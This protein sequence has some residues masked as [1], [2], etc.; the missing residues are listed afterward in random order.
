MAEKKKYNSILVSG[1]KDETLT[2]SKYIKDEETGE[3][4]KES[5]D[6]KVNVTD[7]LETHQIKDGAITNEK[8]AAD[9]VSN[10]NLQDGSV[11]NEKLEDG[12]ITNEKLAENSITKDKLKDNTIGV[13]KLDPEL[14]QTIN[15]ATGLPEDLVET[16]QNV[17]DTLKD[18]QAQLD[19]KQ[20]QI[21]DKQQQI[22]ANDKDI[23]L[24][25]T[26]STQMEETIKGIAATG[27]ASQ[28]TAVTYNNENSK[29]TAINIQSA[30]D[31]VVNKTAIKD[32]EGTLVETPFR[33]IQNEEFIFAKVDAEDKLLFGIQWDGTPKFGKTSA[34]EDSL[35]SQVTLLAGRVAAIMGDE[36]TT[37]TIDTLNELKTFF[38]NIENTQSLTDILA[39]L[40]NVAENLDKTT[41]K[42]EEGNVQDT[43]FRVIEND[44]FI[45]AITDA[46]DRVLFGFNR[47][48][49]KPYYPLNEMYHVEQNEE[50]F[51]LWLDAADHILLGIRRNG[52]IIG[53]IHAVNAL[54][55]VVSALRDKIATIDT[56]LK[57]LLDIFSL[58]DN[59]EHLAMETDAEGKVLSSTNPD[60]SHYIHNAKSETIPTEFSHVED[61]EGRTEITTDAEGKVL[62]YRDSEGIR[63]EIAVNAKRYFQNK[64]EYDLS[65]FVNNSAV[66][67]KIQRNNESLSLS[68]LNGVKDHGKQNLLKPSECTKSY[69]D[70]VNTFSPPNAGY[71]LSNPIECK[72]GDYFTRTGT[73]TGM[74][75]VSD[76]E[77]KNAKRLMPSGQLPG[78]TL[79][80]PYDWEWASFIR[81]AVQESALESLIIS[82]GKYTI[83]K[84][85]SGDFCTIGNLKIQSFNLSNDVAFIKSTDGKYFQLYIDATDGYAIK[86][87]E[88]DISVIQPNNLPSDWVNFTFNGNFNNL[89]DRFVICNNKFL[90]EMSDK[91][92]VKLK[93]IGATVY[94]YQNA[95]HFYNS[96]GNGRF[97]VCL[98]GSQ[99]QDTVGVGFCLFDENM[100]LIEK[101][102][103]AFGQTVN[104]ANWS[105]HLPDFH[106]FV[107]IE[108]GHYIFY[109]IDNQEVTV[110]G[111]GTKRINGYLVHEIKRINGVYKVIGNFSSHD[112]PKLYT[113]VY[114]NPTTNI[115]MNTI[116]L[117][118]DGNLILNY[119]DCDSFIKIRRTVNEDG[120]VTLGSASK[121]YDEAI[122]GRVGGQRNIRYLDSKRVLPEA[123]SFT[124]PPTDTNVSPDPVE[125]WQWYHCHDVKYWGMKEINGK[126]Y[127]TYTMFDNNY[128]TR[129]K[130]IQNQRNNY[131]NNPKCNGWAYEASKGTDV[132]YKEKTISRF[133]QISI[134]WDNKKIIDYKIYEIPGYFSQEMSGATMLSEGIF[135]ASFSYMGVWG[136]YDFVSEL[137]TT[138]IQDDKI[139]KGAKVVFEAKYDNYRYCY[140]ANVYNFKKNK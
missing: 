18:H 139:Y 23:S 134:D 102:L 37:S 21:D 86:A 70:G 110:E 19:D 47:A 80:I 79:Q 53:E 127:P 72:A 101:D 130:E 81:F 33:Y 69:T 98:Q 96:E 48:T 85:E 17:D 115:H 63:H 26:R 12:S 10:T 83:E 112:Y 117:D 13:E 67:T 39:N 135:A 50:F 60:G 105:K 45:K 89:F 7:E 113:D 22:T 9:S 121:N 66:E 103:N 55:Q 92:I 41:I 52:E 8:M 42:D 16:I 15:A 132:T 2:Y 97:A 88:V 51:A 30:V 29:L 76:R 108:D 31:E 116:G 140:R 77:D 128:W 107:Y 38:A 14:R 64:K 56:S 27:G 78:S 40:D 59:T 99:R 24:L 90:F 124:T 32:E 136:V 82:K 104:D 36:D 120:T 74:V 94:N 91:G 71:I 87:K 111:F 73:A 6:K 54:K 62:G 122:I 93:D 131:K 138:T 126:S 1:R 65:S 20:S 109:E 119:R 4:V 129:E 100:V 35:Q 133:I 118:Y 44:K 5:L 75:V 106:D 28:A 114:N 84:E 137:G 95:E 58:Q 57:E 61:P 34:V 123:F 68:E 46:D 43:P 125:D 49:G 25:Q 3:S 11:S